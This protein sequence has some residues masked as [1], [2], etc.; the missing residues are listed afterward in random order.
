MKFSLPFLTLFL[1]CSFES[2]AQ[3]YKDM[4]IHVDTNDF[5]KSERFF[6]DVTLIKK[7][8][9]QL[10]VDRKSTKR[11]WSK[12]EINTTNLTSNKMGICRYDINQ[13]SPGKNTCT[14][15]VKEIKSGLEKTISFTL[16]Y[17]AK[18][19]LG[20]THFIANRKVQANY[21]VIFSNGKKTNGNLLSVN[22]NE[23]RT[24]C[25]SAQ[26]MYTNN[27]FI[28]NTDAPMDGAT[29]LLKIFR[30]QDQRLLC[31]Q[32]ITV[33]YPTFA[34][35]NFSGT[36]GYSGFNGENGSP[37]SGDGTSGQNGS[38][39]TSGTSCKIVVYQQKANGQSYLVI[40]GVKNTGER[41][42]DVL[43]YEEASVRIE[44]SGGSGGNG[45]NGGFGADGLIDKEKEID[46]PNGG[47][48][49][50]AGSGGNAGNGG[51]VFIYFHEEV[52]NLVSRFSIRN[53][54]GISGLAGTLGKGGR[55]DYEETKLLGT[56]LSLK[57]GSDGKAAASGTVGTN[58]RTELLKV[59][60]ADFSS[61]LQRLIEDGY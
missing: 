2:F 25:S 16:P 60:K 8:G 1:L 61:V 57:D 12:F 21:K 4:Y 47:D 33:E 38:A 58:G 26:L 14:I 37:P 49:G 22:W 51:D 48:G 36:S 32:N 31:E 15:K 13:A 45:G 59:S 42:Q 18:I 9:K 11:E 54:A 5:G 30:I 41:F 43:N 6:L 7:R 52:Y 40:R 27:H 24:D 20:N 19:E 35:Y 29:Q 34:N 44:A 50:D 39:G 10:V 17:I 23:F 53:E 55:G 3:R 28:L 56:V 46:T